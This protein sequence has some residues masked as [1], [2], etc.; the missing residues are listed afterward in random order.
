[1]KLPVSYV[2]RSTCSSRNNSERR[3]PA[4]G[5]GENKML[6]DLIEFRFGGAAD[7]RGEKEVIFE[8]WF[9]EGTEKETV[10]RLLNTE[11]PGFG[12]RKKCG[13]DDS[14]CGDDCEKCMF[15]HAE[16]VSRVVEFYYG[17]GT[18]EKCDTEGSPAAPECAAGKAQPV[19]MEKTGHRMLVLLPGEAPYCAVI[20]DRL[21]ELQR[22]VGG[23][24]EITYPFDDDCVVIGNEEAKLIGMAGNRR[25]NGEIY[26]GPLLIAGDDGE[27]GLCSLTEEQIGRYAGA[28]AEPEY[29]SDAEVERSIGF[30]IY[31]V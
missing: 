17:D 24:I 13:R 31:A 11:P 2:P 25:I 21:G 14:G 30:T 15:G 6:V 10:I 7:T 4:H 22:C 5:R 3:C 16:T 9:P 23:L 29:I 1:M 18:R 12:K 26:A 27:G 8:G 19:F 20:Q 28:F